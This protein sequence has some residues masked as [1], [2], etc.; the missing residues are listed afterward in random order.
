[1]ETTD[2]RSISRRLRELYRRHG[3]SH[4]RMSR[5]EP[6]DLYARN[7]RFLVNEDILTFTDT[8]GRLMALRPDVTLSIA[9]NAAPPGGPLQK[10]YYHETVYR[11]SPAG[12]GFR[13]IPQ[14]GLECM[15]DLDDYAMG[16]VLA[17]AARSLAAISGGYI[18][19]LGHMGLV[20][21]ALAGIEPEAAKGIL[22]ELGRR[23]IPAIR[24][25]CARSGAARE[26]TEA[27]CRM[28]DLYG[29]PGQV[30]PQLERLLPGAAAEAALEQLKLLCSMLAAVGLDRG[31]RL[32]LS[33]VNDTGYY[34]GVL[35][36]GCL[37][38]LAGPVLS[39]GRYDNLLKRLGK[40]GGAIGF[41]VYLDQLDRLFPTPQSPAADTLLLYREGDDP[42]AVAA[43]AEDLAAQGCGVRVEREAPE[44]AAFRRVVRFQEGGPA[45][46]TN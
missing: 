22:R 30:L 2:T 10:V 33:L 6:Y 12:P 13:E 20:S 45:S 1:M 15:G 42:V 32:D 39:G 28:A 16:E 37:P 34:T 14:T 18:L 35:F 8:D 27:L 29:S 31:L 36:Q 4:Y 26:R 24:A 44:G 17:L 40:A 43:M 21:A 46:W 19:D 7:K 38:Q 3:Y 23:N 5:F 41:A 25:L 11:T 9:K